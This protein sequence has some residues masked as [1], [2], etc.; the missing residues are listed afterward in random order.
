M[1]HIENEDPQSALIEFKKGA[2]PGLFWYHAYAASLHAE[3][4]ESD[5]AAREVRELLQLFP[6]FAEHVRDEC[7]RVHLPVG[8]IERLVGGLR[9]AGL[10][11]D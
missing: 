5:S 10:A 4:G 8:W 9:R 11:V 1:Y 2:V 7:E 6:N 3:L